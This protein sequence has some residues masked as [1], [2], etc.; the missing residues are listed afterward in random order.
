MALIDRRAERSL[1]H[2]ALRDVRS[3]VRIAAQPN[4]RELVN[5]FVNETSRND[6]DGVERSVTA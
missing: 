1:L 6:G 4:S 2:R 5:G 3:E